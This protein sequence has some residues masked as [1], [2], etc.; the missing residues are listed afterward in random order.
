[1]RLSPAAELAIRG[2]VVLASEYGN[3][4][5]TLESICSQRD[6][7]RQYLVKI[8]ASLARAGLVTPVRGKNG[9]YLLA[10]SP[11]QINL[12]QVIEA[13]EGPL[14]LNY[15][16]QDPTQCD[17][18]QCPIRSV[19]GELQDTMRAKLGEMTLADCTNRTSQ[20]ASLEKKS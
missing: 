20:S 19:W 2:T 13:V 10:R 9:G 3:G 14:A 12:L 11:E 15:C 18:Q 1:M 6:L 17:E 8:F 4:P 7:P 16:Q 5:A